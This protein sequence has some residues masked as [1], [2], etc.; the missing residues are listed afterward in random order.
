M[1]GV[2]PTPAMSRAALELLAEVFEDDVADDG[3]EDGDGE[4]L[5]GD[6][7]VQGEGEGLASAVGAVEL[8]HEEVGV[9][10][11]D[12]EGDLNHGAQERAEGARDSGLAGHRVMIQS[13][14]S[15]LRIS[16]RRR[17]LGLRRWARV[18][19]ELW[20]T[21]NLGTIFVREFA[22]QNNKGDGIDGICD[23]GAVHRD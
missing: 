7:V 22:G 2:L 19:V 23:C 20:P 1:G 13:A 21:D 15:A 4:V 18:L 3:G 14:A 8:S 16:G 6:D 10:E 9:E 5:A 17:L 12:D 11:E